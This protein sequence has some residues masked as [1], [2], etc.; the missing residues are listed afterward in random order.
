MQN[1]ESLMSIPS[2][3]QKVFGCACFLCIFVFDYVVSVAAGELSLRKD[4]L[5]A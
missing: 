4:K 2:Y 1:K 3:K 5:V